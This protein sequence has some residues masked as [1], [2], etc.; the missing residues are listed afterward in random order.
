MN[1]LFG[2]LLKQVCCTC[3][4]FNNH[5]ISRDTVK[6]RFVLLLKLYL[7]VWKALVGYSGN[8]LCVLNNIRISTISNQLDLFF[9][10]LFFLNWG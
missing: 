3:W 1:Y 7:G 6:I 2:P 4:S 10:V 5:K 9:F 8:H